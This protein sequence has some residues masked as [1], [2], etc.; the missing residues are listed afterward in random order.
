MRNSKM[1]AL[2][3]WLMRFQPTTIWR[4]FIWILVIAVSVT[5]VESLLGN[6]LKSWLRL[7]TWKWIFL[8]IRSS[9]IKELRKSF[10]GFQLT[11]IWRSWNLL[12]MNAISTNRVGT[13]LVKCFQNWQRLRFWKSIFN[14]INS[15][16]K[17]F[18]V[19]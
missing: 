19:C 13:S 4:S 11:T 7:S 16:I 15:K 1:R 14:V 9:R 5:R 2:R 3:T 6:L 12:F 18:R 8:I 17:E 10:R